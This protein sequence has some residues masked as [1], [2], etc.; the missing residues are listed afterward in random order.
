[1]NPQDPG[2]HDIAELTRF[3]VA[4]ASRPYVLQVPSHPLTL[5]AANQDLVNRLGAI[6]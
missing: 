2:R 1:M 6:V 5:V 4:A 3:T